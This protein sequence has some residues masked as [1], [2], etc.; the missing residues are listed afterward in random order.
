M[1][2]SGFWRI[3]AD[4]AARVRSIGWTVVAVGQVVYRECNGSEDVEIQGL[5]VLPGKD[6]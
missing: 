1:A 3:A 4:A 2:R 5:G 6:L